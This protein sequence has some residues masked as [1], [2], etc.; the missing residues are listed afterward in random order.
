MLLKNCTIG[1]LTIN[2][3]DCIGQE[4]SSYHCLLYIFT[5]CIEIQSPISIISMQPL[6]SAIDLSIYFI[7]SL[8]TFSRIQ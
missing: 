4:H 8:A 5:I 7:F 1:V 2:I 6:I 3:S